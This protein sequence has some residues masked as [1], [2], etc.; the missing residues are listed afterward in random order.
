GMDL[1]ELRASSRR[2]ADQPNDFLVPLG[3]KIRFLLR[4]P[5]LRALYQAMPTWLR[6][7]ARTLRRFDRP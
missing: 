4:V 3:R 6:R 2:L 7:G 5:G 1:A